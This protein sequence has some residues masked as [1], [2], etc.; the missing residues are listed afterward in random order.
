MQKSGVLAVHCQLHIPSMVK[1]Q[2]PSRMWAISRVME[3][4]WA[5]HRIQGKWVSLDDREN[6]ADKG[7]DKENHK[8]DAP[9]SVTNVASASYKVDRTPHLQYFDLSTHTHVS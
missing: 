1:G 5:G 4:L 3:I 6:A 9:G 2:V 8:G 7:C